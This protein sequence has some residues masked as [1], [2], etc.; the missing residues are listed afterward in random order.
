LRPGLYSVTVEVS[1]FAKYVQENITVEVGR[2]ATVEIK[3]AVAGA[4]ANVVVTSES[5]LVNT[6]QQD[7]SSNI[8]QKS[9]NDLPINGRRWSNF[10]LLTPGVVPDG[11]FGLLSFRGISG[12]LNNNTVDGG[13]NNQAFFS[14]ER[15]R[16]RISYSLSE[17]SVQE[18]QVNTSNYSA[19]F[20]R[21]AGGVVNTV[22]KSGSNSFHGT[23][24]YYDRNNAVG[25]INPF[26][27][28]TQL[29]NGVATLVHIK[30]TDNRQ[31]FGGVIGGPVVKDKFFFF[32]S[33]DQQERNFP[34]VA[35]PS[36]PTAL[37][38]ITVA[39]PASTA[40][41]GST[42][43]T[44]GTGALPIAGLTVAQTLACRGFLAGQT[45]AQTQ[46]AV[47]NSL[48]FL[49]AL[50]GIVPRTGDQWIFFPKVDWHLNDKNLMT[51]S[52][53]KMHWDSP[54]GIQTGAVVARGLNSFGN[55]F[56]RDDF[57]LAHL[58]STFSPSVTNEFR[59]QWGRDNEFE[60]TQ[61]PNAIEPKTGPGGFPPDVF[62]SSAIEFGKPGFLDRAKFPDETRL[63]FANTTAVSK[64]R[65][66]FHFGVDINHVHDVDSNLFNGG[67][68]YSY[69]NLTDFISDQ[70]IGTTSCLYANGAKTAVFASQCYGN[71]QQ[72]FGPLGFP[73]TTIDYAAFVQDDWK[74]RSNFTLNL[75]VR[76]EY[77]Q[78]PKPL[79]PN[80]LLPLTSSF[81][82]DTNNWGPRL[83]FAWDLFGDG[84][85]AIRAGYGIY[86]GRVINSTI[87]NAI[88][89]TGAAG[90]QLSFFIT[91]T[92]VGFSGPNYPN[93]LA[94]APA[95][96]SGTL[97]TVQFAKGFQ[98]PLIHEA[99]VTFEREL[100][101]GMALQASYLL[102]IGRELPIF[103]D[104]NLTPA[105]G[106]QT[107]TIVGG[108]LTGQKVTVPYFTGARPNAAFGS[109]TS[110]SSM[111]S[112]RY[113]AL[114][115]LV[116][117]RFSNY[118]QFQA[119][120]TY[121]NA[122]DNGQTSQTFSTANSPLNPF[123]LSMDQGNSSF[124]IRQRFVFS[125]IWSPMYFSK[126]DNKAAHYLLDNW[127][128]SPI[129]TA[130]NGIPYSAGVSGNG[131]SPRQASGILG[132]GGLNR[133]PTLPRNSF[134]QPR[135]VDVDMRLGR[136]FRI[137]EGMNL[138]VFAEAFNL[139][140]HFLPTG[141][142]THAYSIV[143][144]NLNYDTTFGNPT[145]ASNTLFAQRLIQFG[146]RFD[147]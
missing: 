137:R 5:P 78:L 102:S 142:N 103:L 134:T 67:G 121:S 101:W 80:S 44:P 100:G 21:A 74:V 117:K 91:P 54:A 133:L 99:D 71:F 96:G 116:S 8:N 93:T 70:S 42:G 18:F 95:S 23:G 68:A 129:V 104:T 122:T 19:E 63:Q 136:N 90:T 76:Y 29:V 141:V 86:Y 57:L 61:A 38:P 109:I 32:F 4:T 49:N 108:P 47:N 75:G 59:F 144:T 69:N 25:A 58:Y 22:T 126:S 52:Y 146:A 111:V 3:L 147:F 2:I 124:D 125:G 112:S 115:I 84:K 77:E 66:L 43:P 106:S 40:N 16:T 26:A 114:S 36:N 39:L 123:L 14:E 130:Q 94:A 83:G 41:C 27:T 46:T 62:I 135:I 6:T 88:G 110:I 11:G 73:L 33:Y 10:A 56:V 128:I 35:A 51:V 107:Y 37:F 92:D 48:A 30:P 12:L 113:D 20:G 87:F 139:F 145:S 140:N 45:L 55:D 132:A 82:S 98:L 81:P 72:A 7:F 97:S 15:G 34:G 24:F 143:G 89:S 9:I 13:D 31:Q 53:N 28:Q 119:N 79:L 85:T 65:H 138:L 105:T 17:A 127:T 118:L 64:G 131:P 60:F 1:G 50:T 120:Y